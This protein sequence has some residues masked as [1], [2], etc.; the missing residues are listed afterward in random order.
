MIGA[1]TA[2]IFTWK[3]V[4]ETGGELEF[5]GRVAVRQP[6]SGKL[7]VRTRDGLPLRIEAAAE[8][9]QGGKTV[10]DEGSVE[11]IMSSHGFLT[12]ITV[13]HKHYAGGKL[14]T[15]NH[16]RYEPFK[17]FAADAE[18]KFDTDPQTKKNEPPVI[19]K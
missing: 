18:I 19:K 2:T 14:M 16:Y 11:Y 1:D 6:L 15:E 3:Q 4:T 12:P 9:G 7:W 5:H 17:L 10:R 8:Y 13:L